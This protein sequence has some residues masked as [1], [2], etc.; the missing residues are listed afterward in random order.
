MRI[1]AL[2][3]LLSAAVGAPALHA[4]TLHRC[5]DGGPAP[6]YQTLPCPAGQRQIEQRDYA[7]AEPAATP[8]DADSAEPVQRTVRDRESRAP[9]TH[10]KPRGERRSSPAAFLC[11]LGGK[12]WIQ[13][14]PC[15]AA[16][17]KDGRGRSGSPPG[18]ARQTPIDR[19]EVCRRV[20]DGTYRG[21]VDERAAVS[22]YRRN[23]RRDRGGC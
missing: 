15:R 8:R 12:E 21:A 3:L 22:A 9:A 5:D 11:A 19:A 16:R 2:L 1:A 14:T 4:G 17:R 18:A 6:I 7:D 23:L 10:S 20:R 13:D